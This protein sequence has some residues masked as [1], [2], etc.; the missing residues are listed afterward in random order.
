MERALWF[1][2][3]RKRLFTA[4]LTNFHFPGNFSMVQLSDHQA[5]V[6]WKKL[7]TIRLSFG[8]LH[9][10]FLHGAGSILTKNP[11]IDSL[12]FLFKTRLPEYP[13]HATLWTVVTIDRSRRRIKRQIYDKKKRH[14]IKHCFF[15]ATS[16]KHFKGM[17]KLFREISNLQ[18]KKTFFSSSAFLMFCFFVLLQRHQIKSRHKFT[19]NRY[20]EHASLEH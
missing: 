6:F 19:G 10:T 18:R 5:A 17:E 1:S 15:T 11:K 12:R 4:F 2:S 7:V 9:L 3:Y 14:T 16:S 8:Q 13:S 20:K